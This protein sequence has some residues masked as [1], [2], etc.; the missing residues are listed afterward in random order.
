M[1]GALSDKRTG[2]SFVAGIVST[3]WHIYL[4]CHLSALHTVICQESGS[5]WIHIRIIHSFARNSS[6]L[7]DHKL[8][9]H[10][11]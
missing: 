5:L 4:H 1:W 6:H 3:T 7:N 8:D 11:V 10:K 9:R 2:L